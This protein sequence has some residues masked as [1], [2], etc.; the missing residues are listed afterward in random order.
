MKKIIDSF[1]DKKFKY[2]GYATL[3]TVIIVI[4]VV[5]INLLVSQ[6]EWTLDVSD[7]KL[8]TLSE[9]TKEIVKNIDEPV[10]IVG[11]HAIGDANQAFFEIINKYASLSSKIIITNIDPIKN[12]AFSAQYTQEGETLSEGS[13]IVIAE[14][15]RYKVINTEEVFNYAYDNNGQVQI[16]SLSLEQH[17]T[18]AIKFVTAK[19]LITVYTL[20]G[21]GEEQLHPSLIDDMELQNYNIKTLDLKQ[22]NKVPDD[23]SLLVINAPTVDLLEEEK[24]MLDEYFNS[25]GSAL[26]MMGLVD[27]D[28]PNFVGLFEYFGV[29]VHQDSFVVEGTASN[30]Y[31]NPTL[32]VPNI[33]EHPITSTIIEQSL[34][35]TALGSQYIQTTELSRDELIIEPVLVT[36]EKSWAKD[37]LDNVESMDYEN[38]DALGPFTI[39]TAITDNKLWDSKAGK[40]YSAKIVI[41]SNTQFLKAEAYAAEP[42]F[43]F[44][45]NSMNWLLGE[46]ENIYIRPKDL[47]IMPLQMNALEIYSYAGLTVVIIPLTILII[48]L[49]VWRK[50]R[51]L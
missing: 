25:Y 45:I 29:E 37:D 3:M 13:Y 23:C 38:D 50:R 22:T 10:S 35:L 27:E 24:N 14:S 36:S 21:H 26:F 6:L 32:L 20:S 33:I 11:L 12:P 8:F 31:Q 30:Y 49:V 47:S 17:L 19:S 18:S 1:K 48:G 15:G 7:N 41:I 28:M 39:A 4:I 46:D 5:I 51:H 34:R 9:E 44:V 43:D 42:N 40:Q 2:G 16:N